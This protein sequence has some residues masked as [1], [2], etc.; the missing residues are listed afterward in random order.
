MSGNRTEKGRARS[1]ER[2]RLARAACVAEGR[3]PDELIPPYPGIVARPLP[4]WRFFT[5]SKTA[6]AREASSRYAHENVPVEDNS[7]LTPAG[8]EAERLQIRTI[9]FK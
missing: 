2:E 7:F 4:L 8:L 1:A 6:D 3:D 5:P 9:R